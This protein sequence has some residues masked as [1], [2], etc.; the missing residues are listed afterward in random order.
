[1]TAIDSS[2][3]SYDGDL[4][5]AIEPDL[6]VRKDIKEMGKEIESILGS[7]F[8]RTKRDN[9]H[10]TIQVLGPSKD[11]KILNEIKQCMGII[12]VKNPITDHLRAGKGTFTLGRQLNEGKVVISQGYVKLCFKSDLLTKFAI[13]VRKSIKEANHIPMKSR[14]DFPYGAHITL[15]RLKS[16]LTEGQKKKVKGVF[17]TYKSEGK[18]PSFIA[19]GGPVEY[20]SLLKSNNPVPIERRDYARIHRWKIQA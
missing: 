14:F 7:S 6:E 16:P 4:F 8:I 10:I 19:G 20:F 18:L 13:Q 1:M 12:E 5:I 17:T 2:F 9:T 11:D 15:G 3:K